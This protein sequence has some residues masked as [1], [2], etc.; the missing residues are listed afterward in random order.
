M[1]SEFTRENLLWTIHRERINAE[2][3]VYYA[4]SPDDPDPMIADQAEDNVDLAQDFPTN[5]EVYQ[6]M[7]DGE[8]GESTYRTPRVPGSSRNS[9]HPPSFSVMMA[10]M[11]NRKKRKEISARTRHQHHKTEQRLEET[12][13]RQPENTSY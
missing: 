4:D 11:E 5:V 13:R 6:M 1:E 9:P 3:C 2:G 12:Q 10:K 7:D 8:E